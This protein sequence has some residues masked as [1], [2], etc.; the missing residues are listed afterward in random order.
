MKN[1]ERRVRDEEGRK[2]GARRMMIERRNKKDDEKLI[3]SILDMYN[4]N[5]ISGGY[6]DV[7]ASH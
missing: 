3:K 4:H 2:R 7:Y 5:N 6:A 1:E